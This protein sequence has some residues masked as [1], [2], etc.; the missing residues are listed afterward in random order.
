ME[1]QM[2]EGQLTCPH[3]GTAHRSRSLSA[4]YIV[5][6]RCIG[7]LGRGDA[8][9]IE[10]GSDN[11]TG[12][13][14]RATENVAA[15][16]S[17]LEAAINVPTAFLLTQVDG[18][19][20]VA[21]TWL[22]LALFPRGS[23]PTPRSN[24]SSRSSPQCPCNSSSSDSRSSCTVLH[25]SSNASR[26]DWAPHSTRSSSTPPAHSPPSPP[27]SSVVVVVPAPAA[28]HLPGWS[29]HF[30]LPRSPPTPRSNTSS[31]SSPQLPVGVERIEGG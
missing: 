19:S 13:G 24:T 21:L 6:R 20:G 29:W 25:S 22:E 17:F 28:S 2:S 5:I 23:P 11:Q 14:F 12:I 10:T 4:I 31:R 7:G 3:G 1:G 26:C 15:G 30:P 9:G 16:K 8:S 27:S 18:G